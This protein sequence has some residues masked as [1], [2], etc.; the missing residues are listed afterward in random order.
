MQAGLASVAQQRRTVGETFSP[1]LSCTV[2][3]ALF[4]TECVRLECTQR[5]EKRAATKSEA[6]RF[7]GL[8]LFRGSHMFHGSAPGARFGALALVL[9]SSVAAAAVHAAAPKISGTPSTKGTV[10]VAY[11]FR[12]TASD[13][14]GN[15]LTY[16]IANKPG[17]ASFSS[18]TGQMTGTPNAEHAKTWSNITISVTDGTTKVSLPAFALVIA[19]NANKSPVISGSPA[20]SGKT[21]TAYSF[22][23]TASDPEG[24][25]ISFSIMNKPS[26]AT[27]SSTTGQL[28]GT[29]SATGTFAN[30][31]IQASDGV[32]RAS[33][34]TFAIAVSSGG[35]TTPPPTSGTGTASLSWT[36]PTRKTDGSSL[37]N[38]AGYH[39]NYGTSAS[40][41]SQSVT[42][43][44]PGVA[45][46]VV[47]NLSAGTWYFAVKAYTS[48]STLR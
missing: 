6:R 7:R 43:A 1:R 16:S 45:N 20:T 29:P 48:S 30:I 35:T 3:C 40:S 9:L 18:A 24:K 25:A 32:T 44:N 36:P 2:Y 31:V 4:D 14:D 13:A 15:T 22:K 10:G 37:T 34:P 26:W 17:F 28:S 11:S 21:G 39:I 42:V 12:P 41:L 8:L 23:P 38:L 47:E 27:F 46:Y 5:S 19:P 33:L